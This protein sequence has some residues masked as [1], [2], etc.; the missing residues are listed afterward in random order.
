[1]QTT[2]VASCVSI[3]AS[4]IVLVLTWVANSARWR[5]IPIILVCLGALVLGV[6]HLLGIQ[7]EDAKIILGVYFGFSMSALVVAV[8]SPRRFV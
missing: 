2:L 3:V 1:M 7:G 6:A 5:R 4:I 8:M